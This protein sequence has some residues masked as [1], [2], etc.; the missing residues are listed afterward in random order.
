MGRALASVLGP[1]DVVLLQGSLGTGKT[2][3]SRGIVDGL[4]VRDPSVVSSPS[5]TLINIYQGRVPVYHVDLY[6][7]S[8]SRELEGLGLDDF[9]G[10]SGVTL[11]EWGERLPALPQPA[12]VVCI[13]DLGDDARRLSV[14]GS[15][16]WVASLQSTMRA[17]RIAA[18]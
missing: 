3:L 8:G 15:A 16:A 13:E 5:F 17:A 11:V 7:L 6:R 10:S 12:V 4:G 1:T 14:E 2:T 18:L 9:I